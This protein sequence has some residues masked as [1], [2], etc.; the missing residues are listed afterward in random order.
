[1]NLIKKL[2]I[3]VIF[4]NLI[5]PTAFSDDSTTDLQHFL[6]NWRIQ[7]K[8]PGVILLI[9]TP[10]QHN[11]F[12][13]G[14]TRLNG[15]ER[16]TENT[17][18]AVGS[19]TKTFTS[20]MILRLEAEGKLNINDKIGHYFPQYP[21]WKNITIKQLLNMTSGIP[22][23]TENKKWIKNL[24]SG[25]KNTWT[26]DQIINASYKQQDYF[27]PGNG[28]HYSN[29]NYVLL[30]II[31]EN[32]IHKPLSDIFKTQFFQPL[33]LKNSYYE[34]DKYSPDVLKRMA[35][36]YDDNQDLT[37]TIIAKNVSNIGPP[38]GAIIMNTID[39]ESWINHLL[40]KKDILPEK[41]LNEM[42]DGV[43]TPYNNKIDLPNPK[44]GLGIG[45]SVLQNTGEIIS[46]AG[47]FPG[48]GSTFVWLPKY[49]ILI[50]TQM[51]VDRHG[52]DESSYLHFPSQPLI[53]GVLKI[54]IQNLKK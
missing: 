13:S 14:T 2:I 53:Q 40:I 12:T 8:V 28:W 6:N 9:K 26:K 27:N 30:G 41:Q 1:M 47:T 45:I 32:I 10:T 16:I 33:G 31:I 35:H 20:A 51:N 7:K 15:D 29:T 38:G 18:F 22:N 25:F 36:G 44:Y 17:L 5:I 21:R 34:E 50:I 11:I 23:F 3:S 49:K 54:E 46:Y 48:Y 4:S 19:I 24:K 42:L 52:N 43:P 37:Q 39:L